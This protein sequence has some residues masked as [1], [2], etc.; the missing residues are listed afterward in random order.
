MLRKRRKRWGVALFAI[1]LLPYLITIFLNGISEET[2]ESLT[3][4]Y[5][6]LRLAQE[7]PEDYEDEMLKVQ[8]I[9][10]RTTVYQEVQ[11]NQGKLPMSYEEIPAEFRARLKKAWEDTYGQVL[12]Y[13]NKLALVPFHRLSNGRTRTGKEVLGTEEY[14]Y[15]ATVVCPKDVEADEQIQ[16]QMIDVQNVKVSKTDSAGYV[17]EVTVGK[18]KVSGEQ[19]RSNYQLAS[20]AFILQSAGERMRVTTSG[21]GHGLG[22]SQ[23]T[24][25]EMAKSGKTYKEILEYF[26]DGTTIKEVAEVLINME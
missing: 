16:S 1:A 20:S 9:L 22:L 14:P 24:A 21:V 2:G 17:S 15:L 23:Y 26:F 11:D 19:F 13:K 5:C 25:N 4:S 12:F 8:A 7:V 10:V 3:D 18:E 6:I